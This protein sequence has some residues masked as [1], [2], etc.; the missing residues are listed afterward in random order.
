NLS[1]ETPLKTVVAGIQE[2]IAPA[3]LSALRF[4][5][6]VDYEV[7]CNWKVYVDN[8]LEAY[9]VPHVHPALFKLYD[10]E[11][12]TTDVHAW[13]SV[14]HSPWSGEP[15]R[16]SLGDGKAWYYHVFPNFMLNILPGRLQTNL[17]IPVAPDRCR[18]VFRYYYEDVSEAAAPRIAEDLE[19]SD[20]V[21]Q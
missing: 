17:V 18:V 14:Q 12:Y 20:H 15:N 5:R 13:Y 8:F 9:H 7:R 2:Q 16:Y 3:D 21:Q 11:K 10:F 19:Y 1:G 4:S 6:R